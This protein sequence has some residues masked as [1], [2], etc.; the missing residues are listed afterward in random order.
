MAITRYSYSI[1]HDIPVWFMIFHVHVIRIENIALEILHGG[2]DQNKQS[3]F[4]IM[5]PANVAEV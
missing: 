3:F 1:N 5:D 4:Y 2:R